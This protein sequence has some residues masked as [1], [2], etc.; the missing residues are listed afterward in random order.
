MAMFDLNIL[1]EF[2]W[3]VRIHVSLLTEVSSLRHSN[4]FTSFH[5]YFQV[6]QFISTVSLFPCLSIRPS[7]V[8]EGMDLSTIP[9]RIEAKTK[10]QKKPVAVT[11]CSLSPPHT[12]VT[13]DRCVGDL[14]SDHH[15]DGS[16]PPKA[17]WRG[18][19]R[20]TVGRRRVVMES[21]LPTMPPPKHRKRGLW[22][23]S[24]FQKKLLQCVKWQHFWP[25]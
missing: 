14:C 6:V 22:R 10:T 25:R 15:G 19:G 8:T 9:P 13:M 5:S 16:L 12:P 4:R 17:P 3:Y 24:D 23:R 1:S 20:L 7:L 11:F 2:T 18:V 21:S